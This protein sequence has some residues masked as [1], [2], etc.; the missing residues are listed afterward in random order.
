MGIT[1]T[2][3]PAP[4]ILI[5]PATGPAVTL[6][7][8]Q[9]PQRITI[10]ARG[11]QGIPG[12]AGSAGAQGP[13]G[14]AGATGATGPAGSPG[15]TGPAGPQGPQGATGPQGPAGADGAPAAFV[16][17]TVTVPQPGRLEHVETVALAGATSASRVMLSLAPHTDDDENSAEMLA[18]DAM[19]AETGTGAATITLSFPEI[20]SGPIKLIAQVT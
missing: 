19:S 16:P 11:P 15:A 20:T 6:T 5:T 2:L 1:I 13:Q 18:I 17:L 12:P 14:P 4:R 10:S 3:R 7:G 9:P 8:A